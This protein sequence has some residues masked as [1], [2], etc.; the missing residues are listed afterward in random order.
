VSSEHIQQDTGH[1]SASWA[2]I[3][4]W[5]AA[6]GISRQGNFSR[7]KH[8]K[9]FTKIHVKKMQ[10]IDKISTSQEAATAS[11]Q[12]QERVMCESSQSRAA[13]KSRYITESKMLF[14]SQ[15]ACIYL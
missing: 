6:V 15:N 14:F 3:V 2:H 7:K 9:Y 12:L 10:K 8:Q 4:L 5:P 1:T 13:Q 11:P